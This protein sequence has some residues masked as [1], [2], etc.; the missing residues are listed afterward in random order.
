MRDNLSF[1]T[2]DALSRNQGEIEKKGGEKNENERITHVQRVGGFHAVLIR[3]DGAG[4]G[5]GLGSS[6]KGPC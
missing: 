3:A 4:P 6:L 5:L 2:T 1:G